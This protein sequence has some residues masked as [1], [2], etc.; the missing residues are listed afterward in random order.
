[1]GQASAQAELVQ[2]DAAANS[3]E[4]TN[5]RGQMPFG[6]VNR[7]THSPLTGSRT[8]S[9][10][11]T[12]RTQSRSQ[13]EVLNSLAEWAPKIKIKIKNPVGCRNIRS[14]GIRSLPSKLQSTSVPGAVHYTM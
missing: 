1:M 4:R 14:H 7:E 2:E 3:Q 6:Q 8:L 13:R 5:R 11:R 9:R 10:K 12:Q